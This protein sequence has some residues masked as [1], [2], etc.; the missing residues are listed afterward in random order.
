MRVSDRKILVRLSLLESLMILAISGLFVLHAPRK[1]HVK[2]Q[3]AKVQF[4]IEETRARTIRDTQLK[5]LQSEKAEQ[6]FKGRDTNKIIAEIQKSAE[7]FQCSIK[8]LTVGKRELIDKER[9]RQTLVLS[10]SGGYAGVKSFLGYIHQL[11][12]GIYVDQLGLKRSGVE[13]GVEG[14]LEIQVLSI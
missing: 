6:V 1:S 10:V 14:A 5:R 11:G 12:P 7:V 3:L 2:E 4:L 13:G 8:G 9:A